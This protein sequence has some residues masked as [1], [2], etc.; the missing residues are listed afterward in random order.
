MP[1]AS[2]E[3]LMNPLN[4]LQAGFAKRLHYPVPLSTSVSGSRSVHVVAQVAREVAEEMVPVPLGAS[5][6]GSRSV[7]VV[8]QVAQELAEEMV[9]MNTRLAEG[10]EGKW[11]REGKWLLQAS[12]S[13][14][15]SNPVRVSAAVPKVRFCKSQRSLPA[16]LRR[17]RGLQSGEFPSC[18]SSNRHLGGQ[19]AWL[20]V[21]ENGPLVCSPHPDVDCWCPKDR[22]PSAAM[23]CR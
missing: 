3:S 18:R 11:L 4:E 17:V 1:P 14:L 2:A 20:T 7:H 13:C 10:A 15:V 21:M 6:S 12:R 19:V 22:S 5:V 23:P 8:A 16:A 9:P